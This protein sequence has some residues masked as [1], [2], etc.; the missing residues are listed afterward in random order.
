MF[1]N[2]LIFVVYYLLAHYS[3][4]ELVWV[5]QTYVDGNNS[6]AHLSVITLFLL[7][8]Y[9]LKIKSRFVYFVLLAIF[10]FV[11]FMLGTAGAILLLLIG[12][13]IK[14]IQVVF[15]YKSLLI[16][17]IILSPAVVLVGVNQINLKDS[18]DSTIGVIGEN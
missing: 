1:V 3:P 13:S 8:F 4:F 17:T 11:P 12:Y 6:L 16:V 10:T 5:K 15:K 2:C 7:L 9:P 18:F 14:I